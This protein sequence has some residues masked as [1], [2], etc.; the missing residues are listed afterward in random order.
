MSKPLSDKIALVTGGS[1]GIGLASAQELAAQGAKVYITGRRQQELDAAIALIGSS[2]KGI[3]ADVSRLDDLDKVY[4][5]IAEESGRLDILFANA[6]GGD[7]LP[8]GAITEEHFD[9]IFGTN[10]RG[11]VFTVQKALPLLGAGSSIILTG[12]TVSV[13]GTANFSVYSASKAA[14]RNFARSWA[15]DL[16][17]QGIRVNVVSPGP[18]KTPGLGGLVAEKERQ[19][20]FDALA[21]QVPLGRIGEPAEVGKAVA[22]LASDAASFINA[23]ELFV[24]G[25]MAQI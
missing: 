1:T 21:A 4:A 13:K 3:R 16:Q 7:M 18:V 8:L 5:Q 23:I 20:L 9:R 11:V 12:S 10:V 14:V 22:F 6:G 19:G 24:D 17:G 15:L 2:A 25:G